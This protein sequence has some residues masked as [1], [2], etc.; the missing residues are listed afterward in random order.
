VQAGLLLHPLRLHCDHQL[1]VRACRNELFLSMF[2]SC[3]LTDVTL[4]V[5]GP[6]TV[7]SPQRLIV[8]PTAWNGSDSWP[9]SWLPQ[10]VAT[11]DV[12]TLFIIQ[13]SGEPSQTVLTALDAR[14]WSIRWRFSPDKDQSYE[15]FRTLVFYSNA[16][17]RFLV[18]FIA[19]G[20]LATPT[21]PSAQFR[22]S[23]GMYVGL[24][25]HGC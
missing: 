5:R 10:V 11:S 7:C 23:R 4:F 2:C 1:L 25:C 15:A 6:L 13:H 14:S 18:V 19:K 22:K 9:Q 20:P 21:S 3:V 8:A 16:T 17:S 12:S 24:L